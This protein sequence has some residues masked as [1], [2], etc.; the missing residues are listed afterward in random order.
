LFIKTPWFKFKET[1]VFLCSA[2]RFTVAI[3]SFKRDFLCS[4]IKYIILKNNKYIAVIIQ[5][6]QWRNPEKSK[7]IIIL[8]FCAFARI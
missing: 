1:M 8:I 4:K 2:V 6:N 5:K 7:F 3:K